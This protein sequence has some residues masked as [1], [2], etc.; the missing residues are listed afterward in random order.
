MVARILIVDEHK[1]DLSGIS[2]ELQLA[3][4]SLL[5]SKSPEDALRI[6]STQSIDLIFIPLPK[7]KSRVFQDFFA[8]L[9]QLCSVIPMIGIVSHKN[10]LEQFVDSGFDDFIKPT[11]SKKLL[12]HEVETLMKL[13]NQFDDSLVN[14]MFFTEKRSQRIVS[15]FFD[16]IDFLHKSVANRT[17]IS[18]LT[19]WPIVDDMSDA[20]LFLVNVK[21]LQKVCD[22]CSS[23]RVRR[24]NKHK[25]I[26]LLYDKA[27]R[28]LA[29][30]I[31]SRHSDI[32]Y[33]D[34]IS[35]NMDS[36]IIACKLNSFIKYKKMYESFVD[37]LRKSIYLSAIDSTTEV[38]NR[39]FFEDFMKSHW[40]DMY[41]S[42]I[43]IIDVDKFKTVNDKFGHLFADSMLKYIA[44]TIKKYTRAAD[45]IARYGGDEFIIF[46]EGVS[47]DVALNVA[48]RIQESVSKIIFKEAT[49]T[50]SIGI[51]CSEAREN[52]KLQD[53]IFRADQLMYEAKKMGGNSVKS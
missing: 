14:K 18:Q 17:E 40:S 43:L 3:G 12:L 46:M 33:T 31:V 2:L 52:T 37:K 34:I 8:V 50:V 24:I 48:K 47:E 1:L 32:G 27:H 25:P 26:I 53:I 38:Y 41:D 23:L 5:F 9:K 28:G 45:I 42:A 20:D 16:N 36:A 22:C 35:M 49:C 7:E 4:N 19:Y 51:C 15:F 29:R 13:R 44:S 6:V 21:S 30:Q 39:S 11:I 10:S